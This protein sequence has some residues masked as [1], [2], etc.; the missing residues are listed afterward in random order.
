MACERCWT[1]ANR[2]SLTIGG[3]TAE[4]YRRLLVERASDP[5]TPEQQRGDGERQGE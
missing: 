5:C 4:I 3:H 1:D 2:E